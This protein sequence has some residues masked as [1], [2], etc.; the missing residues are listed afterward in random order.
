MSNDQRPPPGR[1][2][3]AVLGGSRPLLPRGAPGER[4]RIIDWVAHR[5]W[6][7]WWIVDLVLVVTRG[8]VQEGGSLIPYRKPVTTE[9]KAIVSE[10]FSCVTVPGPRKDQSPSSG[11]RKP[12][13]YPRNH[14]PFLSAYPVS[15]LRFIATAFE[16]PR[17]DSMFR[18][19]ILL[20]LSI[21]LPLLLGS[22]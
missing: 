17:N 2:T 1:L 8:V 12:G 11:T 6:T 13:E 5:D 9:S 21:A 18:A 20:Y 7:R 22:A 16:D 19:G 3:P 4:T 10:R 14:R 15:W